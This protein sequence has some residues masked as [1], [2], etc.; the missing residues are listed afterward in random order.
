MVVK[1]NEKFKRKIGEIISSEKSICKIRY[2]GDIELDI[3]KEIQSDAD[4][5]VSS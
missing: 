2:Y 1:I 3:N 4:N 5:A